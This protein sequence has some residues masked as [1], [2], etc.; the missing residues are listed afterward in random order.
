[1]LGLTDEIRCDEGRIG[2]VVGEDR[3]LG[4]ACLGVDA[5]ASLEHALGGGHVD[6]ARPGHHLDRSAVV[7]TGARAEGEHGDRLGAARG[8]HLVHTEQGAGGEDRRVRDASVIALGRA[9]HREGLDACGERRNDVHDDRRRIDRTTTGHVEP[10]PLDRDPSLGHRA[11]R[12]D[13]GRAVGATL[14]VVDEAGSTDRLLECAAHGRV[15]S[16]Q[17]VVKSALRHPQR[18]RAYAVEALPPREHGL[19]AA[20]TDVVD[21][22]THGR[23]DALDVDRGAGQHVARVSD[24]SAQVEAS[25]HALILGTRSVAPVPGCAHGPG[26]RR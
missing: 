20:L 11:T 13:L 5:D 8:V 18:G 1:M 24:G 19:R 15:E 21:D 17:C 14:V 22:G 9:R 12:D 23:Q 25:D 16:S 4:R 10:H 3:D 2:G 7:G 6:V 26:R